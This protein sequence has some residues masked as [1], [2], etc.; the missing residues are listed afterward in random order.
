M[1]CDY[2]AACSSLCLD[3]TRILLI[4]LLEWNYLIGNLILTY[5]I[6]KQ[7][8]DGTLKYYFDT[9]LRE[10]IEPTP[11]AKSVRNNRMVRAKKL[12][13]KRKLK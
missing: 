9:A 10:I 4:Q 1:G 13:S 11:L 7:F 5:V 8:D 2:T 12:G 3:L 6:L